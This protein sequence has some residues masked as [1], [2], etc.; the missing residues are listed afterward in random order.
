MSK[1]KPLAGKCIILNSP[2]NAGKD[3]AAETIK[4]MYGAEVCSFKKPMF[5]IAKTMTGLDEKAFMEI[6]NNRERKESPQRAFYGYSPRSFMIWLSEDVCKPHFGKDYFGKVA[7]SNSC[8]ERGT[9][10]SD[11]GFP[12]EIAPLVAKFGA[13]NVLIVRFTRNGAVYEGDSRDYIKEEQVPKGVKFL[14]TLNDQ[15][16]HVFA[17]EIFEATQS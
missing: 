13:E 17:Q 8:T 3:F 12:E 10:F 1:T 5:D 16:I 4:S 15:E 6:Y 9:V 2:P 11:G 14:D 7:A